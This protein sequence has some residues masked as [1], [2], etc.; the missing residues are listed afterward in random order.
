MNILINSSCLIKLADFGLSKLCM[1]T[2]F[3]QTPPMTDYVTTRWY[4]APEVL[5]GWHT[6]GYAVDLWAMGTIIAELLLR[7]A[8][9]P[10]K[11]SAEQLEMIA[12]HCGKPS[13]LFIT[14]CKKRHVRVFLESLPMKLSPIP[15]SRQHLHERHYHNR[16]PSLQQ[17]GHPHGRS[18]GQGQGRRDRGVGVPLNSSSASEELLDL[19][20]KLLQM[21]PADRLTATEALAHLF[22][23]C[24]Q[25]LL[26]P[27]AVNSPSTSPWLPSGGTG[28]G[29]AIGGGPPKLGQKQEQGKGQQHPLLG[30]DFLFETRHATHSRS[31]RQKQRTPTA[32]SGSTRPPTRSEAG[33]ARSAATA[34]AAAAAVAARDRGGGGGGRGGRGL[35][36]RA[37]EEAG[38]GG[39]AGRDPAGR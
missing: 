32:S 24:A 37:R 39:A 1:G 17:Q 30:S 10:G 35:A 29:I 19:I 9:F 16:Q 25:D 34:R 20:E 38:A 21:D 26:S 22:L 23:L 14:S 6:Y 12:R 3:S 27:L 36:A 13:P 18:L 4:R 11:D 28:A 15:A 2:N 33:G 8:L 31:K 7:E 5:V